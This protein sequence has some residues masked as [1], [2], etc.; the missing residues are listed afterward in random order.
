MSLM[1]AVMTRQTGSILITII[2]TE[3]SRDACSVNNNTQATIK[4]PINNLQMSDNTLGGAKW[5]IRP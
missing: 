3:M 1:F 2:A 4:L 5:L